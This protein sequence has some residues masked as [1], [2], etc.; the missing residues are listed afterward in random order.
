MSQ[1]SAV[2]TLFE[3]RA[4]RGSPEV[5]LTTKEIKRIMFKAIKEPFCCLLYCLFND[6]IDIT[7]R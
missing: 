1:D 6:N 4:D 3:D 2:Y 7:Y 5:D